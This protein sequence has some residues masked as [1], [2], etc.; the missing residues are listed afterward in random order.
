MKEES[1]ILN[2]YPL[3]RNSLMLISFDELK[4][5]DDADFGSIKVV[6]NADRKLL[7]DLVHVSGHSKKSGYGNE[8]GQNHLAV[9]INQDGIKHIKILHRRGKKSGAYSG[10]KKSIDIVNDDSL[11]ISTG[12]VSILFEKKGYAIEKIK[13][14]GYEC[15]PLQLAASGGRLFFQKDMKDA[16]MSIVCDSNIVKIF[17]IKGVLNVEGRMCKKEGFLPVG[18]LYYFWS[19]DGKNIMSK[20]EIEL[21]YDEAT[22]LDGSRAEFLDPLIWYRLD[23][24]NENLVANKLFTNVMGE[25]EVMTLKHPYSAHFC[26]GNA[27][28]IMCPYLALPNDG[29]HIEKGKNFFGASWHSMPEAKKPYWAQIDKRERTGKPQGFHP[30]H[31]LRAY[32]GMGMYFGGKISVDKIASVFSYPHKLRN[33]L[34][35]SSEPVSNACI[36]RWK[37]NKKMALNAITD[38][39]KINDYLYRI[40][41]KIPKWVQ[42]AIATRT[43]YG[44]N[45]HRF[46]YLGNRIFC[47]KSYPMLSTLL[48]TLFCFFGVGKPLRK[49]FAQEGLSYLPHTNTHPRIYLIGAGGICDEVQ[50]SE[51]IWIKKW[52][53]KIPLSHVFSYASPY[54]IATSKGTLEKV[55]FSA[56]KYLQ[57]IREWPVPNAPIDFFLPTRLFWGICIGEIF[58]KANCMEIRKDFT[59]RHKN[60]A[61]Y[62]LISGHVPEY[63]A[64]CP[65]YIT[66]MFDFF[67]KY[68]D[69]WFAGADDIIKYYKARENLIIGRTEK[70][71]KKF[72]LEIK[73]NLPS[74]FSTEVTLIQHVNK[75]IGKIQFATG[76]KEFLDVPYKYIGKN[77]I[78]Y[79]VPS[80]ARYVLIS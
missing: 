73:N 14:N 17:K 66:D 38:D 8:I 27:Y 40:N 5:P 35:L 19:P 68:D 47:L 60:G 12:N 59:E 39:A 64:E 61:D 23:N 25:S 69:V 74:Y 37:G 32:W 63:G 71:G 3:N 42:V 48:S 78:M 55:A 16:E 36:T 65:G 10:P 20:A 30:A 79:N 50:K 53:C 56:S 44:I 46:C 21:K 6:D 43:L 22:G 45:Y 51:K 1:V 33:I 4:F 58:D 62:M 13:I 28:F 31:S 57:W 26:K 80:D 76:N 70:Q 7:F 15:G 18:I 9:V 34:H 75:K 67:Q 49:K 72:V 54:G 2:A 77:V 52:K 24:F 29:I 11:I 41:G